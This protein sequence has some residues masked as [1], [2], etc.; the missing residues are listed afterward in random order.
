MSE[1]DFTIS[2]N[3]GNEVDAAEDLL[4]A[5][6]LSEELVAS[7]PMDVHI[8]FYSNITKKQV[9]KHVIAY[10]EKNFSSLNDVT[11]QIVPHEDGFLF[12]L[13]QGGEGLGYISD[14]LANGY[15]DALII[16]SSN[17]YR[18]SQSVHGGIRL[19][20]LT[21]EDVREVTK[22]PEAFDT[23][24]GKDAL[25]SLR[26]T[27]FGF[28]VFSSILLVASVLSVGISSGVKYLVLD[29]EEAIFFTNMNKTYPHE[30]I[31]E[32]QN[33]MYQMDL[34]SE[35]FKSF[36]YDSTLA[37]DKKWMLEKG[38]ILNQDANRD[39]KNTESQQ[40]EG[41]EQ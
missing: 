39:A 35:F 7:I 12:E 16:T 23:L 1:Q 20:K 25:K 5:S 40:L 9:K 8:G 30:F 15:D 13:Q 29:E 36:V 26:T 4:D 2:L 10:A 41:I 22:N 37:G 33:S 34:S 17:V 6:D 27:G 14:Y 31:P 38:S 11:Y 19:V 21:D 32:M 24:E 3:K 28:F 18:A